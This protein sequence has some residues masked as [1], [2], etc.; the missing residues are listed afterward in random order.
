MKTTTSLIEVVQ[1]HGIA[2]V[3]QRQFEVGKHLRS[4][5]VK[6]AWSFNIGHSCF[7]VDLFHTKKS[8]KLRVFVN[9]KF[10]KDGKVGSRLEFHQY[11][12]FEVIILDGPT[13]N[14]YDLLVEGTPFSK[15]YH[16][17]QERGCPSSSLPQG[18]VLWKGSP[19]DEAILNIDI[20]K[21]SGNPIPNPHMGFQIA[22]YSTNNQTKTSLEYASTF[23]TDQDSDRQ[24]F[25]SSTIMD[26]TV[27]QHYGKE[28]APQTKPPP[29][30]R[31]SLTMN[32]LKRGI[33]RHDSI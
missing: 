30:P 17:V 11:V 16:S 3:D 19:P 7:T 6:V 25:N 15:S 2:A 20:M 5:K 10:V 18:I 12:L 32:G 14:T 1:N 23:P 33:S 4:S 22:N 8:K 31:H 9:G 21:E 24:V 29:K 13:G 28:N 27:K 26:A